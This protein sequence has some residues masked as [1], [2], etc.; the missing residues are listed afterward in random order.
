M[1][2]TKEKRRREV[3]ETTWALHSC[4]IKDP[5]LLRVRIYICR[6]TCEKLEC[7]DSRLGC[8]FMH[9]YYCS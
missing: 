8:V 7:A 3:L 6:H 2:K 4:R 9:M 1:R 5:C